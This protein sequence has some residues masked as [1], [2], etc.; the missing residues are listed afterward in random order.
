MMSAMTWQPMSSEDA[1][2][3]LDE[4][5]ARR[6]P[7]TLSFDDHIRLVEA[8]MVNGGVEPDRIRRRLEEEGAPLPD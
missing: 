7:M 2:G 5:F 3:V 4:F 1:K 6:G 8:W